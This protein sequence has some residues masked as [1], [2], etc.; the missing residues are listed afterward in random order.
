MEEELHAC[1]KEMKDA[2]EKQHADLEDKKKRI[3]SG[4]TRVLLVFYSTFIDTHSDAANLLIGH[5]R[6][7]F[8]SP[9]EPYCSIHIHFKSTFFLHQC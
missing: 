2:L 5:L 1:Y 3:E 6:P 8:L 9:Y 4:R 7:T